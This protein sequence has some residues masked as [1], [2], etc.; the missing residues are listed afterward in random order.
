ME[1]SLHPSSRLS[2]VVLKFCTVTGSRRGS[3]RRAYVTLA[4]TLEAGLFSKTSRRQAPSTEGQEQ[5]VGRRRRRCDDVYGDCRS[6]VEEEIWRAPLPAAVQPQDQA[7][8]S[9]ALSVCPVGRP[10]SLWCLEYWSPDLVTL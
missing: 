8:T 5:D 4:G 1:A 2:T 3:S 6:V 9:V 10:A 7:T